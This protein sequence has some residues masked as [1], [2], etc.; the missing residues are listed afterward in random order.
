MSATIKKV[1]KWG[2]RVALAAVCLFLTLFNIQIGLNDGT[3]SDVNLAGLTL[4]VFTPT[5]AAHEYEECCR[6][7]WKVTLYSGGGWSC[8]DDGGRRCFPCCPVG[9]E[10]GQD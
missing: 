1:S 2:M 10:P 9:S 3:S 8:S 4:R 6:L 7:W 5:A